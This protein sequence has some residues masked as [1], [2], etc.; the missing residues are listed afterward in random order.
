MGSIGDLLS[1]GLEHM[2]GHTTHNR[3]T[4]LF[5]GLPV[6]AGARRSLLLDFMMQGKITE[7]E[8]PTIWLGTTPSGLISDP[9]L[10]SPHFYIGCPSYR[11]PPTLSWLGM[12]T[13]YAGL[14]TQ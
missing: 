8:T 1:L 6:S 12:G 10:S 13:K 2:G 11:N 4:A 9:P 14:H 5:P 7:A 3:F